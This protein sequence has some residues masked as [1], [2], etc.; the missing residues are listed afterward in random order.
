MTILK[1]HGRADVMIRRAVV[2]DEK[3]VADLYIQGQKMAYGKYAPGGYLEALDT[4]GESKLWKEQIENPAHFLHVA[5]ADDQLV[6]FANGGMGGDVL[7]VLS[8]T[9]VESAWHHTGVAP[10]LAAAVVDDLRKAGATSLRAMVYSHNEA[11]GRFCKKLG[12][13]YIGFVPDALWFH[14]ND[15]LPELKGPFGMWEWADIQY[16]GSKPADVQEASTPG[17]SAV[18]RAASDPS[19]PDLGLIVE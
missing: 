6:G 2:G 3:Q 17:E 7:G 13:Q 1:V 15:D 5:Q 4:H 8:D 10:A 16:F 11:G 14:E 19:E 12:A 9:W 18:S